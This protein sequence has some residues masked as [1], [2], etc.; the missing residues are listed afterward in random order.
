MDASVSVRCTRRHLEE[1][2]KAHAEVYRVPLPSSSLPARSR[3]ATSPFHRV[4]AAHSIR[5]SDRF[6]STVPLM[7]QFSPSGVGAAASVQLGP[8]DPPQRSRATREPSI[9]IR[10]RK[11]D[12]RIGTEGARGIL[13][14]LRLLG[15]HDRVPLILA[16]SSSFVAFSIVTWNA[17]Y[18]EK[19]A[20]ESKLHTG[21]SNS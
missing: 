8:F 11:E 21:L 6:S 13:R 3:S 14:S 16:S 2:R 15:P 12:E 18:D 19:Y 7:L 10:N 1:Q 20:N 5:A 9:A 4:I 17:E